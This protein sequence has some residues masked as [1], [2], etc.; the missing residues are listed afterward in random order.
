VGGWFLKILNSDS[1]FDLK[2]S[3]IFCG[4]LGS[5]KSTVSRGVASRIG[6]Q[7][8][9]FGSTVMSIAIERKLP[10]DRGQLQTLGAQLVR[11]TPDYFCD[12][13]LSGA[14]YSTGHVVVLDGLRHES[15][16]TLLRKKLAPDNLLCI[17]VEVED[18]IRIERVAR[19]S[20][21]NE[22]EVRRLDMHSTEIQVEKALR[23]LSELVV[24]NSQSPELAVDAVTCWLNSISKSESPFGGGIQADSPTK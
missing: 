11:E 3:L 15:I 9:G 6:A 2:T 17:Y 7:W 1:F 4:K 12:R 22:D 21:L 14:G 18:E 16:L 23:S 5:G 19:R 8:N 13:V 24:D 10:I 20:S